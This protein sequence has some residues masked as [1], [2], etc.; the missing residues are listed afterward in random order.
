MQTDGPGWDYSEKY[1]I[2]TTTASEHA[3]GNIRSFACYKHWHDC[4]DQVL[5]IFNK[6][7]EGK[8]LEIV[9]N[10]P[11]NSVFFAQKYCANW[12]SNTKGE[13][14]PQVKNVYENA[15]IKIPQW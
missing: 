14:I 2:G 12:I 1:I 9:P 15:I 8:H 11:D 6:R 10:D 5:K 3:T 4:I 7:T 13:K